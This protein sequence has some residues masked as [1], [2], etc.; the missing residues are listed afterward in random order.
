MKKLLNNKF[1][2]AY[3][4]IYA[5]AFFAL[6][7]IYDMRVNSTAVI[8][9]ALLMLSGITAVLQS[10]SAKFSLAVIPAVSGLA[11]SLLYIL[12]Q[13]TILDP[14]A[15]MENLFSAIICGQI[16]NV[17]AG[18]ILSVLLLFFSLAKSKRKLCK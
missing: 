5:A 15:P 16:F 2:I 8:L 12:L 18:V 6:L 10:K 7:Y 9:P 13:L 4:L 11:F 1:I 14:A 17:S 3:T